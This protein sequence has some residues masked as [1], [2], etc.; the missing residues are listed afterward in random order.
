M[1][2]ATAAACGIGRE[3]ALRCPW[4]NSNPPKERDL[5]G[6][7]SS[8]VILLFPRVFALVYVDLVGGKGVWAHQA[9]LR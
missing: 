2:V 3:V 6:R 1:V 5:E 8:L 9:L 4:I 7:W